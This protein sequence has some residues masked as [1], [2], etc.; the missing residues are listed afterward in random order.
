MQSTFSDGLWAECPSDF[1]SL[2]H[3]PGLRQLPSPPDAGNSTC[4]CL[5][6]TPHWIF[7]D[8]YISEGDEFWEAF[9][10]WRRPISRRKPGC[11]PDKRANRQVWQAA[12][13]HGRDHP[14]ECHFK[15]HRD[16]SWLV[17]KANC[18][19]DISRKSCMARQHQNHLIPG[20]ALRSDMR[21][22]VKPVDLRRALAA[23]LTRSCHACTLWQAAFP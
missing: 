6:G 9:V 7:Y 14:G 22:L 17:Q 8:I 16:R 10:G 20:C 3:D 2:S 15:Q 4:A 11:E 18:T 19:N 1:A 13:M 21:L 5:T 12:D 23:L